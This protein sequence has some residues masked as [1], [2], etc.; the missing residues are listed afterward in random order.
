[1]KNSI[2][3]LGMAALIIV[4]YSCEDELTTNECKQEVSYKKEAVVAPLVTYTKK[5][6]EENRLSADE[7][8]GLRRCIR[9]KMWNTQEDIK[10]SELVDICMDKYKNDKNAFKRYAC[11]NKTHNHSAEK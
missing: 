11:T 2:I 5:Y 10:I 9:F 4:L 8:Y 1:M 6:A 7:E 3:L